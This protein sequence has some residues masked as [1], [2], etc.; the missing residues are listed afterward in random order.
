MDLGIILKVNLCKFGGYQDCNVSIITYFIFSENF[1]YLYPPVTLK[2][3]SGSPKPN[4]FL[5]LAQ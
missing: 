2:M 3:R 4:Q 1:I 5:S